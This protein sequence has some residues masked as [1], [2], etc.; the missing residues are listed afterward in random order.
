MVIYF[1]PSLSES[2]NMQTHMHRFRFYQI[3]GYILI[4][5]R[6]FKSHFRK[7]RYA[8]MASIGKLI[9]KTDTEWPQ[10]HALF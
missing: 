2:I 4:D 1:Q 8:S 9:K 3:Y 6:V 5:A 7:D 10:I